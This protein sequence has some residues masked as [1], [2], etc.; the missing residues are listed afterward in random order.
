MA[1][2]RLNRLF[3]DHS[4]KRPIVGEAFHSVFAHCGFEILV[5][6]NLGVDF[7]GYFKGVKKR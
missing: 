2:S 5:V 4:I 3:S 6:H 7:R 1:G